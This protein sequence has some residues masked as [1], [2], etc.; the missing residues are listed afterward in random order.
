LAGTTSGLSLT[1]STLIA[2]NGYEGSG[3]IT[4]SNLGSVA[5]TTGAL[6]SGGSLQ[7]GAPS[8][9]AEAFTITG[10][11]TN[12][13]RAVSF[14]RALSAAHLDASYPGK[15]NHNYTLTGALTGS[16]APATTP[17]RYRAINHQHRQRL[18]QRQH[19]NFQRD[20]T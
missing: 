6:E 13:V 1:G 4:G 3:L 2:V 12:G 19:P 5:F 17:R 7:M 9:P 10:N 8:L 11:G 14:S 20:T 16:L 15:R 18:L